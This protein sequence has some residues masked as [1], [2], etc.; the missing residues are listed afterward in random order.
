MRIE[1]VAR[2]PPVLSVD[3]SSPCLFASTARSDRFRRS[4]ARRGA[5]RSLDYPWVKCITRQ[6]SGAGEVAQ[7]SDNGP[8]RRRASTAPSQPSQPTKPP[9]QNIEQAHV[10]HEVPSKQS[11]WARARTER[12]TRDPSS[13]SIAGLSVHAEIH[14]E[15]RSQGQEQR[16]HLAPRPGL[17]DESERHSL[18]FRKA[19][20]D[21]DELGLD[22]LND[23]PALLDDGRELRI[24]G[25]IEHRGNE[26]DQIGYSACRCAPVAS[27]E[28]TA[29]GP[30]RGRRQEPATETGNRALPARREARGSP[31][32]RLVH[33][34]G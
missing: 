16:G 14:L 33:T 22:A 24:V 25:F 28:T 18:L 32:A 12:A 10:G 20:A 9:G 3:R 31:P 23:V 2:H 29:T 26:H 8:R 5:R 27:L 4:L 11:L 30:R 34:I 19:D 17:L 21:E 1:R 13:A 6:P 7:L 15:R